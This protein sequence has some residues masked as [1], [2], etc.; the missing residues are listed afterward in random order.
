MLPYT[1]GLI[2]PASWQQLAVVDLSP[3]RAVIEQ[4]PLQSLLSLELSLRSNSDACHGDPRAY[5][6]AGSID[7]QMALAF[8]LFGVPQDAGCYERDFPNQG[9]LSPDLL[10]AAARD[11]GSTGLRHR[12]LSLLT[13]ALKLAVRFADVA[14][15]ISAT[16][17]CVLP[18]GLGECLW[19]ALGFGQVCCWGIPVL[20]S[21]S[22]GCLRSSGNVWA[23]AVHCTRLKLT[24]DIVLAGM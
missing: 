5:A 14:P 6:T 17:D 13:T 11:P 24:P 21:K 4:Q 9:L 22:A 3:I 2:V 16:C 20:L 12:L 10:T 7:A 18:S 23:K 8:S 1:G 19:R 15:P